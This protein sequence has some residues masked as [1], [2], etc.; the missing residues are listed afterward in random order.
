MV[1]VKTPHITRI[2]DQLGDLF[3]KNFIFY[4]EYGYT[5]FN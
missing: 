2:A 5:N 1:D 3:K 4:K